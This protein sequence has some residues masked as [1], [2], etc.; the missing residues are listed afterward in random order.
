MEVL[1]VIC[2]KA[3]SQSYSRLQ[4]LLGIHQ[5]ISINSSTNLSKLSLSGSWDNTLMPGLA[6]TKD[7][8]SSWKFSRSYV[9]RPVLRATVGYVLR[10][11]LKDLF[12]HQRS[13]WKTCYLL[14]AQAWSLGH[15]QELGLNSCT[16][17]LS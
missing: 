10:P 4:H 9:L 6:V 12:S 13:S 2:P 5:Q 1:T 8:T 17:N 3:C 14:T 16:V 7:L 15:L 11:V